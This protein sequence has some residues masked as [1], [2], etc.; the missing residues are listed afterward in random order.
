MP[1]SI[2]H[3]NKMT[4]GSHGLKPV[5]RKKSKKKP[6]PRSKSYE[7]YSLE[8]R[9]N[10]MQ[11][12]A[13][14]LKKYINPQKGAKKPNSLLRVQ[15]TNKLKPYP[16]KYAQGGEYDSGNLGN[17]YSTPTLI[18]RMQGPELSEAGRPRKPTSK[19]R[20]TASKGKKRKASKKSAVSK[21]EKRT[22]RV[23]NVYN[24]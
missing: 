16:R 10:K 2:S 9:L 22:P 7:P 15:S 11:V 18:R 21:D 1:S 17:S 24:N 20:K 6:P 14:G 5:R 8:E 23:I 4:T 13:S 19:P 3:F 12:F